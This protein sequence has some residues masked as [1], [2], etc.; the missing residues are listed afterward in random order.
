ME[1]TK[2]AYEPRWKREIVLPIIGRIIEDAYRRLQRVVGRDEIVVELSKDAEARKRVGKGSRR[3]HHDS[4]PVS[5]DIQGDDSLCD[6]PPVW[7]YVVEAVSHDHC[8]IEISP[9]FIRIKLPL[10]TS[11]HGRLLLYRNVL[12]EPP[13]SIEG[14]RFRS[15]GIGRDIGAIH[16]FSRYC[17]RAAYQHHRS[18]QDEQTTSTG[19]AASVILCLGTPPEFAL[20]QCVLPSGLRPPPL[21]HSEACSCATASTL[22]SFQSEKNSRSC[23][24]SNKCSKVA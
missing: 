21:Y 19:M 23:S 4:E 7:P 13:V 15:E 12:R 17:H 10:A 16:F 22:S 1:N 11:R 14:N 20:D 3:V 2:H 18:H 24:C 8:P 5:F 6:C 9:R